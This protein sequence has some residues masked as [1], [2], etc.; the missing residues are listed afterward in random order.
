MRPDRPPRFIADAMLGALARWLRVLGLDTT[1]DPDWDDPELADMAAR[2]DRTLLTRDRRLVERRLVRDRHLLVASEVVDRQVR[3]VLE[4]FA[5]EPTT[6]DLFSRCLRCNAPLA[7]A[8]PEEA[9]R[10]VP[11]FVARTHDSFHRCPGCR[12]IYWR[13]SHVRR[14]RKRLARMGVEL[15]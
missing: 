14:M 7:P 8:D 10:H 11:P 5:L 13:A 3:Q 4:E 2:E 1:Y 9:R 6:E 15:P 12:R